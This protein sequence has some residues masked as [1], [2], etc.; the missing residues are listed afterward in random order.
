MFGYISFQ[1][2]LPIPA[3]TQNLE[4]DIKTLHQ[5]AFHQDFQSQEGT[6]N[7]MA[8]LKIIF[9]TVKFYKYYFREGIKAFFLLYK[10]K[11]YFKI[12]I[13]SLSCAIEFLF[14]YMFYDVIH[15]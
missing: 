5:K 15:I 3:N 2:C 9:I 4:S 14:L 7:E 1:L 10:T 11:Y 6:F 12:F 8:I 13:T